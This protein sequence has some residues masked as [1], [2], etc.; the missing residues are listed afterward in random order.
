MDTRVAH[1]PRRQRAGDHV[2]HFHT[3]VDTLK[4]TEPLQINDG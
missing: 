4:Y 3:N 2:G 1:A